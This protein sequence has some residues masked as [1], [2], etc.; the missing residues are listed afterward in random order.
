VL[1]ARADELLVTPARFRVACRA[2]S[3]EVLA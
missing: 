3:V 2:A 1:E